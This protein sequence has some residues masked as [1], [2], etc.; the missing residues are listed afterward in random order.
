MAKEMIDLLVDGGKAV[1]GPQIGQKLGPMGVNIQDVLRKINEKTVSFSGMRVPVKLSIDTK[2][3]DIDLEVGTP[4]ISELIKK[5]LGLEKGSGAPNV[6][7]KGN[8]A[9]EQVIKLAK[10][11]RDSMLANTL[12]NAV[13]N[14]TGSC[15]SI[16]VL[17]EG[18]EP[19]IVEKEIDAG[20]YDEPITNE[21]SESSQEKMNLMKQ[22]FA[23]VQ[24]KIEQDKRLNALE[25][26]KKKEAEAVAA[27]GKAEA[28]AKEGG[29]ALKEEKT[30]KK[31][32]SKKKDNH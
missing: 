20:V 10:M 30:E 19:K 25:E 28:T 4:P 5:E 15:C 29:E 32:E 8:L 17:I 13:K 11:K 14:I 18:K 23:E 26:A 22:Q 7:K 21:K 9:I 2:T 6:D 3:K 31:E 1:A 16:G 24:E 27:S 12:K